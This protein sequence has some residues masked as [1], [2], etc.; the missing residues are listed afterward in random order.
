M[1]ISNLRNKVIF[2]KYL[3][4]KGDLCFDSLTATEEP[5]FIT[6]FRPYQRAKHFITFSKTDVIL[7]KPEGNKTTLT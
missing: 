5:S 2:N 3:F 6:N 4:L 1:E 7:L